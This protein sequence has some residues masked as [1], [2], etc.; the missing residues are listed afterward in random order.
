MFL[1]HST[2]AQTV[3]S[4]MVCHI[5]RGTACFDEWLCSGASVLIS[6]LA[7]YPLLH[8]PNKQGRKAKNKKQKGEVE[9]NHFCKTIII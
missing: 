8:Y 3:L 6:D 2:I 4:K 5:K 7:V 1:I 9:N